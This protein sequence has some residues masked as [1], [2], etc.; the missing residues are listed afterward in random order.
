M[1]LVR[2][3]LAAGR[4][5]HAYLITGP[6]GAGKHEVARMLAA[7]MVC[8]GEHIPCGTCAHCRKVLAGIHPDV[9]TLTVPEDK[10]EIL[11]E[12]IRRLRA[13]AYV[14]PNE[15]ARKVYII[16]PASAMNDHSQN[17]LL[18]IL[19]EGPPY[20]SFLLLS[21]A[22]GEV[23]STIRS[24]CEQVSLVPDPN[25]RKQPSPEAEAFARGLLED[26]ELECM[27]RFIPM[28]QMNRDDFLSFLEEVL[29]ALNAQL[30]QTPGRRA[31]VIKRM[32][33]IKTVLASREFYVSPGQLLGWLCAVRFSDSAPKGKKL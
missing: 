9:T 31:E 32:D 5:S 14:T 17:A 10:R 4:L 11:V 22:A 27:T 3:Q 1:E 28:E 23:L 15:A 33:E 13:D 25:S 29:Q 26:T 19:E 20:A 24:R 6:R 7:A 18:K 12:Q 30:R 2:R 16:D 8:T 21:E